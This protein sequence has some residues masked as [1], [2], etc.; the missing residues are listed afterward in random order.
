MRQ[1]LSVFG[2]CGVILLVLIALVGPFVA[3][4]DPAALSPERLRPPSSAHLMGTENF[5]RDVFSR[6]LFGT[7]VSMFVGLGAVASGL[8]AGTL[9]GMTAGL[10]AG[11]VWDTLIM[12]GMDVVLAFPLLVLVPVL[13]GILQTRP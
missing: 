7:R 3:P 2:L 1:P 11:K 9:L 10:H 5:G 12:R 8:T 6:F 13:A 4:Y